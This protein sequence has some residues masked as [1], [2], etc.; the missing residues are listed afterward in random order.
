MIK[1]NLPSYSGIEPK[2]AKNLIERIL[3]DH[4]IDRYL[5]TIQAVDEIAIADLNR[6]F[7]GVLG[8]TDVLS[9]TIE[10]DPLEGEIYLCIEQ[11]ENSAANEGITVK[12]EL[13]RLLVH[14]V[15]HLCA[16]HHNSDREL[17]INKELM[18]KYLQFTAE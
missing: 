5:I 12:E 1:M 14:G 8:V 16:R 17:E 13:M 4:K 3:T 10:D 11:A 9:F 15:L 6:R 7:R 18:Q 2:I